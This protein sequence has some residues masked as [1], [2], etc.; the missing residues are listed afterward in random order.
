MKKFLPAIIIIATFL[1][2]IGC[3]ESSDEISPAQSS[4]AQTNRV[5]ISTQI[6]SSTSNDIETIRPDLESSRRRAPISVRVNQ[7]G[8]LKGG[9]INA[10]DYEINDFERR[11]RES[12]NEISHSLQRVEEM[13]AFY[14]LD[15]FKIDGYKLYH[16]NITEGSI[17]YRFVPEEEFGDEYVVSLGG[18]NIL[19][20]I[21]R[22]E[23]WEPN[24]RGN[25]ICALDPIAA[26]ARNPQWGSLTADNMLYNVNEITAQLGDTVFSIQVPAR[27][28][29]YGYEYLR[30][31]ARQVIDSAELVDVQYELDVL[32]QQSE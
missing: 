2:L 8:E 27:F 28:V 9:I 21:K 18:N 3:L 11:K 5:D 25:N 13:P 24:A 19:L 26:H 32:R 30:D 23:W 22:W 20:T 12:E 7:D 17:L 4:A 31:L 14:S 16:A 29:N 6:T 10:L 1:T 15:N